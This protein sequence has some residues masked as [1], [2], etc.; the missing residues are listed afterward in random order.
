MGSM[1]VGGDFEAMSVGSG[2]RTGQPLRSCIRGSWALLSSLNC[3][4]IFKGWVE[5]N[6]RRRCLK[7]FP[8]WHPKKICNDVFCFCFQDFEN[9]YKKLE[10]EANQMDLTSYIFILLLTFK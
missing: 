5:M 4:R 2:V 8:P 6:P 9:K 10:M 1:F 7:E 3:C